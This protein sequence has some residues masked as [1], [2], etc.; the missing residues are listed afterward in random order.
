MPDHSD[1]SNLPPVRLQIC[2]A[3][4]LAAFLVSCASQEQAVL[5][6]SRITP[7]NSDGSNLRTHGFLIVNTPAELHFDEH[8]A[9]RFPH[10]GYGIYDPHNH[11]L[12]Q[13]IPNHA[14][15]MS[16]IPSTVLLP[17][18]PYQI[19]AH[20]PDGRPI[21]IAIVI[22]PQTET[23]V[24]LEFDTGPPSSVT[25]EVYR[26]QLSGQTIGWVTEAVAKWPAR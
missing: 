14:G 20:A 15:K 26:I 2:L 5:Q 7:A 17:A 6:P 21:T 13:Y 11:S 16:E 12:V 1:K 18:G 25:G 4:S 10:T 22:R 24:Y 19:Q 9:R 8:S 23:T 3:L